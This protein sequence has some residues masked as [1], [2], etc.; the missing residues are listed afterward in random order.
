MAKLSL[1]TIQT[2][3]GTQTRAAIQQDTV[4]DYAEAIEA[5]ETLPPVTVYHDGTTYWLADGFHRYAAH[6][7]LDAREIDA[8]IRQGA[9][10]DA[11]LHSVGANSTHGLRRTNEDKRRAVQVLLEDAEWREWSDREI[12]RRAG[13]SPSTVGSLRPNPTVQLGQST[14]RKGADGRTINTAN[15]GKAKPD[16]S[17]YTRERH[18]TTYSPPLR[19][20]EPEAETWPLD[21]PAELLEKSPPPGSA[22]HA[23]KNALHEARDEEI[24][25]IGAHL[26]GLL[27]AKDLYALISSPLGAS[28]G[29]PNMWRL[30]Q[31]EMRKEADEPNTI[32]VQN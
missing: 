15:I 12:G 16:L 20:D 4:N 8:D 5:G 25:K 31:L 29:L 10:R 3:G 14:E 17:E 28:H 27:K 9:R 13:V 23:F 32:T 30:V 21:E 24:D 18:V 19:P 7:K 6:E 1:S 2:D 26:S 22:Y 11:V